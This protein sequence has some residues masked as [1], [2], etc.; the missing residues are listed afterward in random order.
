MK[1]FKPMRV[2]V[3]VCAVI[4]ALFL[5]HS[6]NQ[7]YGAPLSCKAGFGELAKHNNGYLQFNLLAPHASEPYFNSELFIYY[8]N[9]ESPPETLRL[10]REPLDEYAAHIVDVQLVP[11]GNGLAMHRPVP[12]SLPTPGVTSRL[13]PFDSPSF[14]LAF[15][16]APP[17]GPKVVMVR[18]MTSD[19]ILTCET[20]V[21]KWDGV[22]KLVIQLTA[23]RN[24]FVQASVVIIGLGALAFGILLGFIKGTEDLAVATA[25]YFFSVWSVR[26]IFAPSGLAYPTVFDLWLII[27]CMIVLFVVAWRLAGGWTKS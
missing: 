21:S 15:R 18:N 24:P 9:H 8:G 26:S 4:S 17:R 20:F 19:F 7:Q 22:D 23:R 10:V 11:W 16:L 3:V 1:R 14:N 2:L 12:I 27:V 13:F 25:S 6:W 5:A